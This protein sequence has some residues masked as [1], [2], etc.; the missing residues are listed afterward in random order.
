[1]RHSSIKKGLGAPFSSFNPKTKAGTAGEPKRREVS[2][3]E[4][5][6][7]LAKTQASRPMKPPV[8]R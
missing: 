7:A 2:A 6:A 8:K 3:A 5:A 1:M 4:D